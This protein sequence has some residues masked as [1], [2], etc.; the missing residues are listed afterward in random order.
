MCVL[1]RFSC[2]QL[3]VTLWTVARQAP[4]SMELSRQEYWSRLPCPPPRDL[5]HP[6][7]KPRALT[8]PALVGRFFTTS[9]TWEAHAYRT[10]RKK[11]KK[12]CQGR[13]TSEEKEQV[14]SHSTERKTNC[15]VILPGPS[16]PHSGKS[17]NPLALTLYLY[18]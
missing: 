15:C 18:L 3:F 5:P 16:Q 7:I 8:S 1:S 6:G 9:T 11:K 2:V 14:V 17:Q 10:T 4:L 12:R 13:L